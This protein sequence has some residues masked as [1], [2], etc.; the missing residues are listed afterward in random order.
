MKTVLGAALALALVSAPLTSV[1]AD[2]A[3]PQLPAHLQAIGVKQGVPADIAEVRGTF[4][5]MNL[6]GW[7]ARIVMNGVSK[8]VGSDV[9]FT[10]GAPLKVGD[11]ATMMNSPQMCVPRHRVSPRANWG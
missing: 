7:G 10:F 4:G 1:V 6:Y 3:Q 11:N 2:E 8:A 5:V 9:R